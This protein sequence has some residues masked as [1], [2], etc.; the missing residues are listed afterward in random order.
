VHLVT[1]EKMDNIPD[2]LQSRPLDLQE[3]LHPI[4]IEVIAD[5]NENSGG[6][7]V[8]MAGHESAAE[9]RDLVVIPDGDEHAEWKAAYSA[10]NDSS[11][12]GEEESNETNSAVVIQR[13]ARRYILERAEES[14][15]DTLTKERNRL[16]RACKASANTVHARYRKIYLGPVPHL[17]LCLRWI[18][19]RA[20]ASMDIPKNQC[21]ESTFQELPDLT[22]QQKHMRL[23]I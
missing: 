3:H 1:F 9:G 17:L 20:Q 4:E 2:E 11:E 7:G 6:S 19:I 21:T 16:F 5:S 13:A 12:T 18:A 22:D 15:P 23:V 8:M 14:S 10:N